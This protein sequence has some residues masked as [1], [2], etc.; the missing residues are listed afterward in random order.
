MRKRRRRG[1]KK[2]KGGGVELFSLI[3]ITITLKF[4]SFTIVLE[5]TH[6]AGLII[7]Q[8]TL[9]K[10]FTSCDVKF[11]RKWVLPD[12]NRQPAD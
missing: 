4:F 12:S 9:N 11:F 6:L 2:K 8:R 1:R 7:A 10:N 5:F 3:I